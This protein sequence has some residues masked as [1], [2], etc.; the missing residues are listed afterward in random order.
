[1]KRSQWFTLAGIFLILSV[2][3][4]IMSSIAMKG[5]IIAGVETREIGGAGD[6]IF[7]LRQSLYNSFAMVCWALMIGFF[8][9]GYLEKK[10]NKNIRR[11]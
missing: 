7:P 10:Q 4:Q 6:I 2:F 5:E 9:C 1:M 8:I 3:F 11:F